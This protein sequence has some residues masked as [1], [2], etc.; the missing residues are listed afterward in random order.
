MATYLDQFGVRLAFAEANAWEAIPSLAQ[1]PVEESIVTTA[2]LKKQRARNKTLVYGLGSLAL[3]AATFANADAIMDLTKQ[4][5]FFA[6]IPIATVFLFS[7]VH[8]SFTGNL[9]SAL[10]IEA[11]A[12]KPAKAP[13]AEAP[14]A[15]RPD[16]RPRAAMRA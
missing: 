8:G 13:V 16:A 11:S 3:Y 5:K 10:G 9:W 7:W 12:K 1:P 14:A 15:P 4:G 2:T 6:I